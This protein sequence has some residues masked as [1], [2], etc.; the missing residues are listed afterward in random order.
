MNL[1]QRCFRLWMDE[2]LVEYIDIHETILGA[3]EERA[4]TSA[5]HLKMIYGE[6]QLGD[7]ITSLLDPDE[8]VSI[9]RTMQT[10]TEV[11]LLRLIEHSPN[12]EGARV[13]ITSAQMVN[14]TQGEITSALEKE[15]PNNS[16]SPQNILKMLLDRGVTVVGIHS[17]ESAQHLSDEQRAVY[18]GLLAEHDNFIDLQVN[19]NQL[20]TR[21]SGTYYRMIA[22]VTHPDG[23]KEEQELVW[24]V[25]D[26]C[27][28]DPSEIWEI[29]LG[30]PHE[31]DAVRKN[32]AQRGEHIVQS[33]DDE[34]LNQFLNHL[35]KSA[36]FL[37][38]AREKRELAKQERAGS[39]LM[40]QPP[41]VAPQALTATPA[42]TQGGSGQ[43]MG[44]QGS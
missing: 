33:L 13:N 10:L 4:W 9:A 29:V 7:G 35:K 42:P 40:Q 6:G 17:K 32:L 14:H 28:N 1:L 25:P 41:A 38:E 30:D 43:N 22:Q 19:D 2:A 39:D 8:R 36:Q 21:Y 5:W 3:K 15:D 24:G 16:W 34:S 11:T 27:V 37:S 23:R 26:S 31:Q 18:Q 12:F 44:G 20:P